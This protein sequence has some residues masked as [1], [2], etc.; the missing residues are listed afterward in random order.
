MED[1]LQRTRCSYDELSG[2]GMFEYKNG[3]RKNHATLKPEPVLSS[4]PMRE[5]GL[6]FLSTGG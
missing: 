4:A 6:L 5:A 2:H 1:G 3:E